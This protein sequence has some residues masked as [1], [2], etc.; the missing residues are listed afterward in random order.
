[1]NINQVKYYISAVDC[2]SFS[3]AAAE[4]YI[5]AQGVSKAIADLEHEF[6]LQLLVRK[7]RGVEPTAFGKEFY[8]QAR[9]TELSF[10]T[11][12]QFARNYVEA[13][14]G[15]PTLDLLICAPSFIGMGRVSTNVA[16][17]VRKNLGI[18]TT[19][20]YGS[21]SQC[22]T[23]LKS[24]SIDAAISLGEITVP[25]IDCDPIGMIPCG[26]LIAKSHPFAAMKSIHVADLENLSIALWPDHDFFNAAALKRLDQKG[27]AIDPAPIEADVRDFT[28]FL[29]SGGALVVPYISA[30]DEGG[31][32]SVSIPFDRSEGM[33]TPL[34]LSSRSLN[35]APKVIA[36]K[37]FFKAAKR[38]ISESQASEILT[39]VQHVS[40]TR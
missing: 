17:F 3:A 37:R 24:G 6:G 38:F 23:A 4:H 40:N 27:A 1:M 34:C 8:K 22:L 10:D 5:T 16:A 29:E 13:P 12:E 28:G 18:N 26:I 31:I 14:D 7:N 36:L 35:P 2:G 19:V 9:V 15:T 30:I 11:L 25:G 32:Q 20:S 21:P 39:Q 33:A